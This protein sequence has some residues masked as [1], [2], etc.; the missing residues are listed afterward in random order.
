MRHLK[1]L[2]IL[3][4]ALFMLAGCKKDF[5]D[6]KP[7]TTI[8][9]PGPLADLQ[10]LLENANVL[11]SCT[12][13][14]SLIASDDYIFLDYASWQSAST[15]TERNS[16]IWA[17]DI[18]AGA[19]GIPDWNLGYT[20]IYYCNNVLDMLDKI[21]ARDTEIKQYNLI[22]GWAHFVRA[23]TYYD[24]ARNFSP[25]YEPSKATT[26][27]G[28]PIRLKGAIDEVQ[29]RS[30]LKQTYDQ[31]LSDIAVSRNVL[32]AITSGNSNRPSLA[33]AFALY[34]RIYLGMHDYDKAELYADSAIQLR[35]KLIDYNT[36]SPTA[37]SPFDINNEETIYSTSS[38]NNYYLIAFNAIYN[39]QVTI[40]PELIQLYE[41]ND[42]RL[43]VYFRQNAATKS[44]YVRRGYFRADLP[45]SGLAT[46]E[47]YL[48][49]AECLARR[50]EVASALNWV[51]QLLIK[52]FP[53]SGFKPLI[54]K[55]KTEALDKILNERRKELVW[56][57]LR[58]SDLKRLNAE[59]ANITLTRV[60]NGEVFT[61]PA[62]DP[63]YV[64]PIPDDE[65]NTSKIQ[66]NN[67]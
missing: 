12:P 47:L 7:S 65:I 28:L 48:T 58:W 37:S 27:L 33:A 57:T 21:T 5:L 52:R 29:Q 8:V 62:N 46:D 60:L 35:G 56:R 25:A 6:P 9:A 31:I 38:V 66:Q 53:P 30:S 64:F 16:Y 10:A 3:L 49:K 13:A 26:A 11:N 51:N 42:L 4:S 61:L 1:I 41:P 40:N 55:D 2:P 45:F 63:R 19:T 32:G 59:G 18:Y 50:N 36:I 43:T 67:R 20:A 15:P 14:L 22:K 17:R 44:L 34:S 24:L 39:T 54:A 23:Y